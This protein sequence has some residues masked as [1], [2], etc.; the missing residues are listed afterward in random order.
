MKTLEE[1]RTYRREYYRV[2]R[3]EHREMIKAIN[4]KYQLKNKD[5]IAAYKKEWNR[6]R[7]LAKKLEAEKKN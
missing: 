4:K 1:L 2:Y 5:K 3:N 7:R 6:K